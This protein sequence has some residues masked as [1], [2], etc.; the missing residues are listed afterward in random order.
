MEFLDSSIEATFSSV[1]LLPLSLMLL[2]I[3]GSDD[4]SRGFQS[5]ITHETYRDI[6]SAYLLTTNDQAFRHEYQ[7]KTV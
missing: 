1:C 4:L 3:A 6:P 2:K 5:A 7:L